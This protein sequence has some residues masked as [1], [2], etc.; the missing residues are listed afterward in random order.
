MAFLM[1]HSD[2]HG[3]FLLGLCQ[4][5]LTTLPATDIFGIP[6]DLLGPKTQVADQLSLQPAPAAKSLLSLRFTQGCKVPDK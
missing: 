5:F 2:L 6:L 4:R 1:S 3:D